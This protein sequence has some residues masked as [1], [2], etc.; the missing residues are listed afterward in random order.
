MMGDACSCWLLQLPPLLRMMMMMMTMTR[1]V[2]G[3]RDEV[4]VEM[5]LEIGLEYA[6]VPDCAVCDDVMLCGQH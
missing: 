6:G 4:V 1:A 2:R 3:R 5:E